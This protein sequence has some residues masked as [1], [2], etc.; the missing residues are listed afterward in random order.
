MAISMQVGPA[1]V[2]P[3]G[4][5]A[6]VLRRGRDGPGAKLAPPESRRA[7]RMES[8]SRGPA[9]ADAQP[10]SHP[11]GGAPAPHRE[12][13]RGGAPSTSASA[14]L[15]AG[16][17]GNVQVW[18]EGPA[19][20]PPAVRGLP[21]PPP[22]F[23]P[24]GPADRLLVRGGREGALARLHLGHGLLAGTEIQI[25][26]QHGQLVALVLT[27]GESSRETLTH[28]MREVARRLARK[29]LTFR[30]EGDPRPGSGRPSRQER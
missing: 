19:R 16:A 2:R 18:A 5:F 30:S 12:R 23:A 25:R 8:V 14:E 22:A 9:V 27:P 1:R 11:D 10:R 15:A 20:G 24:L 3:P 13:R 28:A 21:R 26:L 6:A 7:T 17:A 4:G 29:G